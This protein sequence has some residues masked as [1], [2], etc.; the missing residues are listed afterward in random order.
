M[1]I[2]EFYRIQHTLAEIIVSSECMKHVNYKDAANEMREKGI[3]KVFRKREKELKEVFMS[4]TLTEEQ[5]IIINDP[6]S[7]KEEKNRIKSKSWRKFKILKEYL[8]Q[9]VSNRIRHDYMC[10]NTCIPCSIDIR[11]QASANVKQANGSI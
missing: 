3:H 7:D 4:K 8:F 5:L 9:V 11:G 10:L 2:F 6:N 1:W